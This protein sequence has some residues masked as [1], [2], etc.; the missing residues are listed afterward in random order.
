M[1]SSEG[2]V[3]GLFPKSSVLVWGPSWRSSMSYCCGDQGGQT[4]PSPRG[5][6]PINSESSPAPTY[7][8]SMLN[9]WVVV[10]NLGTQWHNGQNTT[11]FG[12][13][14]GLVSRIS[15]SERNPQLQYPKIQASSGKKSI[16]QCILICEMFYTIAYY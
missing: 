8:V 11:I 9:P 4:R 13:R 15:N 10:F 5:S 14:L 1:P 12:P 6:K 2:W 16:R 7:V 3:A